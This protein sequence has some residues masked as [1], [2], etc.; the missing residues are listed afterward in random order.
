M[1]KKNK[2]KQKQ[3]NKWGAQTEDIVKSFLT[4]SFVYYD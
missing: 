2:E 4:V 3:T 1:G